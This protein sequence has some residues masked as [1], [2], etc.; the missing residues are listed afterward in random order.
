MIEYVTSRKAKS[1]DDEEIQKLKE[2]VETVT[3]RMKGKHKDLLDYDT[4]T[5]KEQL[6]KNFKMPEMAKFNGNGDPKTHLH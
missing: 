1:Q 3:Q 2:Q 6:P 4:L 5:F